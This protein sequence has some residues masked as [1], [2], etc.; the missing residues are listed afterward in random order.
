MDADNQ[1]ADHPAAYG[2]GDSQY[3]NAQK[4][5]VLF[6]SDHAAGTG[7]SR[8]SDHFYDEKYR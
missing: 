1:V 2:G 4:I 7:K 3:D 8:R 6:D 5:E